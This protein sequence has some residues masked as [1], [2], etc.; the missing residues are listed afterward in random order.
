MVVVSSIVVVRY[1]SDLITTRVNIETTLDDFKDEVCKQWKQFTP[2]Y[3]CFLFREGGKDLS[4]DC[5]YSIQVVAS[6]TD[7]KKKTIFDIFLRN[8]THVASSSR[9]RAISSIS[10]GSSTSSRNN[11]SVGMYLEDRSKPAKP[12]LSDGWPKVLGEI[13]HVFV[14]GVN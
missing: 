13:G 3:I 9:S 4:V 8:V 2:L 10:N 14:E 6:P 11:F 12:L 1:F 7:S 5:D